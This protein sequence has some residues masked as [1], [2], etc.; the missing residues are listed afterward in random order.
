MHL[1]FNPNNKVLREV[2]DYFMINFGLLIYALGWTAFLLP[3]TIT[4]GGVTGVS[5]IIYYATDIPIQVSYTVINLVLL[6]FA[7]KLIGTRFCIKTLYATIVLAIYLWAFQEA[8]KNPDGSFM[9][10]IGPGQDFMACVLGAVM[11]GL[12][13]GIVFINNGSTGGTDI[14]AAVVNKYRNITIGRTIMYCDIIIISSCYFVFQDWR[15]VVFGFVVLVILSYTLDMVLNSARQSVQFFI[16]SKKY[17]EIAERICKDM[18]RGVTL[19]DGTGWYSKNEVK[20]MIIMARKNQSVRIF[21]LV[22]D[23]DPDAFV[24]QSNVIGVYGEGF[25]PIK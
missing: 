11:C 9:L 15:R 1:P 4:T 22:K 10:L 12:G 2:K 25:D 5:A 7:F 19:L 16:I 17:D 18:H 13:L 21:R 14:I 3:Y 23:I 8:M 20:T 6:A 24:T